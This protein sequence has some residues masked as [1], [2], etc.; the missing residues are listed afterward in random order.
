MLATKRRI[1][2]AALKMTGSMAIQEMPQD[3]SHC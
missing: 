2:G 1:S 3:L